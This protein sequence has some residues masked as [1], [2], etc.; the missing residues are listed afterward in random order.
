MSVLLHGMNGRIMGGQI[1]IMVK[2]SMVRVILVKGCMV[3]VLV[4]HW[5]I[6]V[7]SSV[8]ML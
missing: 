3:R 7:L 4:E 8:P 1:I 6:I 2:G 5:V